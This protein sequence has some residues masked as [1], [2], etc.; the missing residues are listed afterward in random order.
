MDE[1]QNF[2]KPPLILQPYCYSHWQAYKV[3]PTLSIPWYII[4]THQTHIHPRGVNLL[5]HWCVWIRSKGGNR[6]EN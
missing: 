4:H 6:L 3:K 5:S 2:R 1:I